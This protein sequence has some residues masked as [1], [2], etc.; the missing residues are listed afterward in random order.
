MRV[1]PSLLVLLATLACENRTGPAPGTSRSQVLIGGGAGSFLTIADPE[2]DVVGHISGV[3]PNRLTLAA[4]T[5]RGVLV[6]VTG[7]SAPLELAEIDLR[8]ERLQ[9]LTPNSA[10]ADPRRFPGL[11]VVGANA[12]ALTPD[13]RSLLMD[14]IVDSVRALARVDLTTLTPQQVFDSLSLAP[15][16]LAREPADSGTPARTLALARRVSG[17]AVPDQVFVLD[18]A[19]SAIVDSFP[20]G[21][22]VVAP[23]PTETQVLPSPDGRV[24]YVA[25]QSRITR[26]DL[27]THAATASAPIAAFNPGLSVSPDGSK[28]FLE[29]SYGFDDP[30]TGVVTIYDAAL[31][32]VGAID[33][34]PWSSTGTPAALDQSAASA[35]GSTLY[36]TS[37]TENILGFTPQRGQLF[38]IRL[39]SAPRVSVAPLDDWAPKQ[40]VIFSSPLFVP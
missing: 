19:G 32:S 26:Y 24:V 15:A 16:G 2:G 29:G 9:R 21:P 40:I 13:G 4:D 11:T 38:T 28:L 31:D 6:V 12:I 14:A 25:S 34:N 5:G 30:G 23:Y 3:P 22:A 35:D 39:G 36:V 10:L 1:Y 33:L 18:E 37:G 7:G 27:A 17:T 20:V 8:L